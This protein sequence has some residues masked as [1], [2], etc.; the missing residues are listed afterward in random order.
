MVV[1]PDRLVQLFT[2]LLQVLQLDLLTLDVHIVQAIGDFQ[3][4]D[5]LFKLLN[6]LN[7][8]IISKLH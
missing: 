2:P 6:H 8:Y 3:A 7:L 5:L 4:S 1:D